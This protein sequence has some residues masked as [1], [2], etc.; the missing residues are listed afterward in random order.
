MKKRLI[1]LMMSAMLAFTFTACTKDVE[2]DEYIS[3]EDDSGSED[4]DE[5]TSKKKDDADADDVKDDTKEDTVKN[6]NLIVGHDDYSIYLLKGSDDSK[7]LCE[8]EPGK[9]YIR[10]ARII[11]DMIYAVVYDYEPGNDK[12]M[13][14]DTSGNLVDTPYTKRDNA[15][16]NVAWYNDRIYIDATNYTGNDGEQTDEV[17]VY[18][19]VSRS[20]TLDDELQGLERK[21]HA[22]GYSFLISGENSLLR[23]LEDFNGKIYA[24]S[25]DGA[26]CELDPD[27]GDLVKEI[28]VPG[29]SW[30]VSAISGDYVWVYAF[31]N[32]YNETVVSVCNVKNADMQQVY[33]GDSSG[34]PEVVCGKDGLF[35]GYD[36]TDAYFHPTRQLFVYN[37]VSK[38]KE[39]L[40]EEAEKPGMSGYYFSPFLSGV[41]VSDTDYYY[42]SAYDDKV[43]WKRYNFADKKVYETGAFV[44]EYGWAKYADVDAVKDFESYPDAADKILYKSYLE[45]VTIKESVPGAV[46]INEVIRSYDDRFLE[47]RDNH[48]TA[49]MLDYDDENYWYNESNERTLNDIYEI[50]SHYL[51]VNYDGYDY[52]GGAHGM[53]YKIHLLFDINTGEE[54]NLQDL[55]TMSEATFKN[56]V[57]MKTVEDWKNG[58]NYYY[59][60]YEYNPDYSNELFEQ[61]KEYANKDMLVNY[62]KEGIEVEYPPYLMGPYASGYICIPISYEE[63]GIDINK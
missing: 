43:G 49:E 16:L 63:L 25:K 29:E 50:G 5:E 39:T 19:P 48:T 11:D 33:T 10:N 15:Y 44:H 7:K 6:E 59:E 21:I 24:R 34:R 54:L 13:V 52:Y 9:G 26:I 20:C 53:P 30:Y 47:A 27:T 57:A 62:T 60:S 46:K 1:M 35:Y 17:M 40:L 2:D 58:D 42:L 18:D 3:E 32:N 23:T 14:Y 22:A 56:L 45:V 36:Q 37:A 38:K 4:D 31:S 41:T 51:V 8:Y 55:C 61:A 12:L 28:I